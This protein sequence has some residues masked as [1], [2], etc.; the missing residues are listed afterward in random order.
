MRVIALWILLAPAVG[1]GLSGCK[2]TTMTG[3]EEPAEDLAPRAVDLSSCRPVVGLAFANPSFEESQ[4][5]ANNTGAPMS[6]IKGWDGCCN[7]QGQGLTT[8]W[9]VLGEGRCGGQAVSITSTGARGDVL[10]QSLRPAD[11]AGRPFTLTAWVK[12]SS[13]GAGGALLLDLYD[14][15]GGAVVAASPTLSQVQEAWAPLSVT[16]QLP[17]GSP[18]VQIRL[19]SSGTLRA[20]AD[21]VSLT[22][23]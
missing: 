5:F 2:P 6:T 16:G 8:T 17:A 4:G 20:L 3:E 21:D 15:N 22:L 12:V 1:L 10:N 9:T 14:L 19:K 18:W 13:I 11:G 23:R 7:D